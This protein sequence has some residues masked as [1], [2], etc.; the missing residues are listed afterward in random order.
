MKRTKH[1]TTPPK[2]KEKRKKGEEDEDDKH[3][4]WEEDDNWRTGEKKGRKWRTLS[5][6]GVYFLPPYEPHGVKMLYDGEEIELTP[7]QEEP[8]TYFVRY[9]ET[10]HMQKP[11][12]KK[13]FFDDW[14]EFLGKKA[15][16]KKFRQM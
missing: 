15:Q 10:D 16:D 9:L 7:E 8:I 3:K 2:R 1:Q 11:Q 13:N 6:S 12:F 5:H 14:K 4:W